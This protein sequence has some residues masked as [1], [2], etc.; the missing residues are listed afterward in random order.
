MPGNRVTVVREDDEEAMKALKWSFDILST[1]SEKHDVDPFVELPKRDR[2]MTIVGALEPLAPADDQEVAFHR[3]NVSGW[4][5]ASI[6]DAQ[7]VLDFCAEHGIGPDIQAIPIQDIN[8]AFK[9]VEKG[10]VRFRYVIDMATLRH[11]EVD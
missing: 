3:K 4:L 8:D 2:T 10:D 11:D 9:R 7:E 1:I 6:A 5:I